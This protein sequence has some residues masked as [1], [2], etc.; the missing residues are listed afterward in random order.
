M[1]LKI[2]ENIIVFSNKSSDLNEVLDTLVAKDSKKVAAF[3]VE[4]TSLPREIR[5][6]ALRLVLN[7]YVKMAKELVLSDE[8]MYR[9]NWY[10][11]FSE[12]QLVN[13][14]NV[15]VSNNSEVFDETKE[16]VRFKRTFYLLLLK[17]ADA[18]GFS[19]SELDELLALETPEST[20]ESFQEFMNESD[21]AFYDYECNFD[22]MSYEDFKT[23]LKKCSTVADIRNI[24]AKYD[25]NVPKRLKKDE[26]VALVLE[27]LRRQGKAD[28]NTEAQLK[29]MSA[30]SLQRYAKVNGVKASTEMKKDDIIEFIMN[31]I[32]SSSKAVRKPRIELLSLPELEEFQF[33]K[34]YLREVQIVDDEEDVQ[35]APVVEEAPAVEEAPVQEEPAVEETPVQEE[36]VVEET[37]VQEEVVAEEPAL[38]EVVEEVVEEPVVE[39]E[40]SEPVEEEIVEEVVEETTSYDDEL[41]ATIIRLL[42]ERDQKDVVNQVLEDNRFSS[43]VELYEKRIAYLEEMV[44]NVIKES[45]STPIPINITVSY[46]TETGTKEV[47]LVSEPVEEEVVV[48]EVSPVVVDTT[49]DTLS[50]GERECHVD[51]QMNGVTKEN[52]IYAEY[53]EDKR[54]MVGQDKKLRKLGKKRAKLA[55]KYAGYVAVDGLSEEQL[56]EILGDTP[57]NVKK[58]RKAEKKAAKKEAKAAKYAPENEFNLAL[59]EQ[60]SEAGLLLS[61]RDAAKAEKKA[62][63]VRKAEKKAA[64]KA[65]KVAKVERKAAKKAAEAEALREQIEK[66]FNLELIEQ[67]RAAG[68]LSDKEA[69]RLAKESKKVAKK[70]KKAEKK[71]KKAEKKAAKKARKAAKYAP[72]N[73]FNLALIEKEAAEGKLLAKEEKASKYDPADEF[74][75][76]LIEKDYAEGKLL[77]KDK[78]SKYDPASEFNVELIQRDYENGTLMCDRNSRKQ[79]KLEKIRAKND[80][81]LYRQARRRKIRGFIK[82]II[83]TAI[84]LSLAVLTF[85]TLTDLE[86]LKGDIVVKVDDLLNKYLPFVGDD[87]VVRTNV[88]KFVKTVIDFVKG[89]LN[90]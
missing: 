74:N 43:M 60:E 81:R 2:D 25:I 42:E 48:E 31:R 30:I 67:D 49:F 59:I 68:K 62:R 37:P 3:L 20:I 73:E 22:G 17:N 84:L 36:V 77:A 21:G 40:V 53:C 33:S 32:E 16:A 57:K 24:A 79:L 34:D 87:G 12:F 75:L 27:G 52:Y 51:A 83:V 90:K 18:V 11:K 26:L 88:T 55:R 35:E 15:L 13:F 71:A 6:N 86:I 29:K 1:K 4:K 58:A 76:A 56:I 28:E 5:I 80:K 38:E 7:D 54:L 19:D 82:F 39:E 50:H 64:K 69:K 63:K 89:L 47:Q 41:L 66:D 8:F 72:E 70:A 44:V 61:E 78:A 23:T 46:P 10:P 9:L 45:R 85:T 14:W 65:R